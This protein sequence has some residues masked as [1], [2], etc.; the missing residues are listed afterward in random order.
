LR[1]LWRWTTVGVGAIA[2]AAG[3]V[4][5]AIPAGATTGP[6]IQVMQSQHYLAPASCT[7]NRNYKGGYATFT[8]CDDQFY[9]VDCSQGAKGDIHGPLYAA[10]GCSTQLRM[11]T[12][13]MTVLC[14]NPQKSTDVLKK[15]YG[16]YAITG[17]T[18]P[19]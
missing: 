5:A 8:Y 15:N 16:E 2:L 6:T 12:S 14:V 1:K 17:D 11:Y 4:V 19:C 9:R 13:S 10:N 7:S 3:L 18:G